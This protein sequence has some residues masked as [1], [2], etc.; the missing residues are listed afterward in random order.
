MQEQ[1]D[2]MKIPPVPAVSPCRFCRLH[3]CC[4]PLTQCS[5]WNNS[6]PHKVT[7]PSCAFRLKLAI[8]IDYPQRDSTISTADEIT[9]KCAMTTTTQPAF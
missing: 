2:E 6:E 9:V 7:Q 3:G 4:F 1:H 5:S 8:T